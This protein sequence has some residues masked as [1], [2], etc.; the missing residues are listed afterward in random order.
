MKIKV[1][2]SVTVISGK[3]RNDTGKVLSVDHGTQ[4]V[5]VEGINMVYKHVK[6]SQRNPQGGRLHKEMPIAACKLMAL[7]PKTNKPTRIGYRYLDDGTKERFARISGESMGEVSPQK[8]LT[9]NNRSTSDGSRA[10]LYLIDDESK[11][12]TCR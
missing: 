12:G 4:K 6:P 3:D 7:C 5:V 1:G 8:R 2:D 10:G 11:S 9:P